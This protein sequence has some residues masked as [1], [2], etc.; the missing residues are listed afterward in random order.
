METQISANSPIMTN[1]PNDVQA[2]AKL[3]HAGDGVV[4]ER[5]NRGYSLIADTPTPTC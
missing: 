1:H 3:G 5:R 2:V 4:K